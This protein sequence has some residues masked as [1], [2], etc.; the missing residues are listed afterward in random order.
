M[1]GLILTAVTCRIV[2]NKHSFQEQFQ[3]A[4]KCTRTLS[5]AVPWENPIHF[6]RLAQRGS[7][8][9]QAAH[10]PPGKNIFREMESIRK[11]PLSHGLWGCSACPLKLGR[12]QTWSLKQ[13]REVPALDQAQFSAAPADLGTQPFYCPWLPKFG[14]SGG[15]KKVEVSA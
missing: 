7:G 13:H 12:C 14:L 11:I 5:L 2:G 6:T 4:V 9:A 3:A 10:Q 1:L 8:L 15:C